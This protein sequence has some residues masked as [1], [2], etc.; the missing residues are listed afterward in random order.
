MI[1]G[2]ILT[3]GKNKRMDGKKKLLL[4]YKGRRFLDW[5]LD[6]LSVFPGIYLSV[7]SLE[8]WQQLLAGQKQVCRESRESITVSSYAEALYLVEDIQADA[9]PLGGIV[10]GLMICREEALFV[11]TCD[12]PLIHSEDVR[13][14]LQQY[15]KNKKVTI[16]STDGREQPLFGVYPKSVLP[17]LKEKLESGEYKMM[18][19]LKECG[20]QCVKMN[21]EALRNVNTIEDYEMLISERHQDK[22]TGRHPFVFAISGYKNTGKTTLITK[23]IKRLTARGL[24]VAVIKHDGHDFEPDVPG[25]DSY[26]H[27]KAGAFGTAVFSDRRF[28]ITREISPEGLPGDDNRLSGDRKSREEPAFE[29]LLMEAFPEADII[30]I[31]GLKDSS[32]PKYVC[33]YPDKPVIDEEELA[34]KIWEMYRQECDAGTF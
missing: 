24:K 9:G 19:A 11:T 20:Y 6:A 14:I 10:S 34:G 32:Y 8:T 3:G 33:D 21:R 1:A 31:E 18:D 2:C 13:A 15:E 7:D 16:G 26:R 23:L 27:R 12:M 4:P 22:L 30:L 29:Q 28:M 25:T 17:I 5:I